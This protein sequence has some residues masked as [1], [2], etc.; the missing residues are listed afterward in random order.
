MGFNGNVEVRREGRLIFFWLYSLQDFKS[1]DLEVF[2][3]C[4]F[5][6]IYLKY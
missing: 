2:G 6:G 5:N 3:K 4:D 1:C